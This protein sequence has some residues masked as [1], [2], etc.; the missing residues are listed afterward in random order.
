M[1]IL[2]FCE[3]V[4]PGTFLS[5]MAAFC[6]VEVEVEIEVEVQV[7]VQVQSLDRC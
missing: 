6:V 1:T 2:R 4:T 5:A 7:Q 3:T